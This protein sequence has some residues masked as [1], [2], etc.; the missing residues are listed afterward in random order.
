MFNRNS[1]FAL[2]LFT[3]KIHNQVEYNKT[4]ALRSFSRK[5][6]SYFKNAVNGVQTRLIRHFPHRERW[7]YLF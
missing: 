2:T 5:W 3:V 6:E 1:R 7:G 4:E